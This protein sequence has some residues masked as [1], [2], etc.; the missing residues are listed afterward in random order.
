MAVNLHQIDPTKSQYGNG[1]A[2]D[3]DLELIKHKNRSKMGSLLF[4]F[5]W[6]GDV[7]GDGKGVEVAEH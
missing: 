2:G 5:C 7:D 1:D 6:V 3:R 4:F